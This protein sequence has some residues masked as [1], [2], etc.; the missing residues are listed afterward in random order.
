[1]GVCGLDS[2]GSGHRKVTGW[3][4]NDNEPSD[5]IKDGKFNEWLDT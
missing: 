2:P 3:C 1:M 4:E 5:S